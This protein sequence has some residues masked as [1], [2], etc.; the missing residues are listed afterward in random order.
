MADPIQTDPARQEAARIKLKQRDDAIR[1]NG[2]KAGYANRDADWF[3]ALGVTSMDEAREVTQ[4]R[5]RPTLSEEAKHGRFRFYQGAALGMVIGSALMLAA[6]ALLV[7]EVFRQA[8]TYGREMAVTGAIAQGV[9]P[10]TSCIP[11]EQLP[12]GRV[13]P[14]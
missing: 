2:I 3:S 5:A 11:G 9:N 13:C 1:A 10:P 7:G 4:L 8:G 14:Q 12:D 6:G